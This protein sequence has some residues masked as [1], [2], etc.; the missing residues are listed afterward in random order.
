[1]SGKTVLV[2]KQNRIATLI[3]N[4]PKVMNAMNPEMIQAMQE[5]LDQ[6]ETD[7]DIRVVVVKGAGDNFCSGADFNLF[8]QGFHRLFNFD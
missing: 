1:M 7:E 2:H 8:T 3:L 5:A 4:R 6:I